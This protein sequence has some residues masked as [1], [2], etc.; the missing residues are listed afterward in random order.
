MSLSTGGVSR[1]GF[2]TGAGALALANHASARPSAAPGDC[3]RLIVDAQVHV[4]LP[5]TPDQP[6]PNKD[7]VPQ[8]PEPFTIERLVPL[9]DEAG[10]DRVVLV[11]PSWHGPTLGNAY[12]EKA[13]ADYPGRFGIMGLGFALDQPDAAAT[14]ATWRNRPGVLGVRIGM[15]REAI[16]S[17]SGDWFFAAA[18]KAG[19][20]I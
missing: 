8:M 3:R 5:S 7:A 17:G 13:A 20:P 18:E 15:N 19:V 10:V 2:L 4:W 9:M 1:R 12:C 14:L 11:P 6:W 16:A